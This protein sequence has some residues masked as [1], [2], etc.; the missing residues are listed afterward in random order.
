ML[1]NF[2]AANHRSLRDEQQL[3]LHAVYDADRPP[4]TDWQAVPV[5]G[6]FG[7][8]AAGKSNVVDALRYMARMV[9]SS[10]N[11]AEPDGG[12]LREPFRLDREAAADPSWFVV[13]LH[14]SGVRH[15]YGF[16]VDDD[17]VLQEWLYDYPH[18]RR[19]IIF[20]RDGEEVVPGD[21]QAA[22]ELKVIANVTEPNVLFLSMAARSRQPDFRPVYDWF[23]TGLNFSSG[24]SPRLSR[25]TARLLE[26]ADRAPFLLDLLRASDLGIEDFG[27]ERVEAEEAPRWA[28]MRSGAGWIV[29][30]DTGHVELR[31]WV[32]HRGR[33]GIV[34]M[35]LQEESAGTRALIH[36]AARLDRTLLRGGTL[37]ID[38][39]DSSLHPRLTAALIA[40][41]QDKATNPHGGQLLFTS[42]DA[43]LLGRREGEDILRRDQVWFAEKD[44]YGETSLVPLSD[45]K[46]RQDENR[47][48]RY[49]GG[50]YGGVPLIDD[51]FAAA[52]AAS[53]GRCR[54]HRSR[55]AV[56]DRPGRRT[57]AAR[58]RTAPR[59]NGC[60]WSAGPASR[61]SSTSTDCGR[62]RRTR[63]SP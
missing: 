52:V 5:A 39:V 50:S 13:D 46:P 3:Q 31:P 12:V 43:T 41:F 19:R 44:R 63:R 60:W 9:V 54:G 24:T 37:V 1:L 16:S 61:R 15:T 27:V 40:L 59:S 62:P 48:R 14:L 20:E 21:S 34:R 8:N 56:R 28:T 58:L 49:L 42:H 2:R 55:A 36:Q 38:E 17:A 51:S 29:R 45:F 47:E 6:I 18:G 26:E 53:R 22:R 35:S 25:Q 11:I 57:C 10:H 32:G 4:G 33:D 7:A 23:S 30:T